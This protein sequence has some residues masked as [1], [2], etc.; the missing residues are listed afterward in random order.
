MSSGWESHSPLG[1]TDPFAGSVETHISGVLFAGDLAYKQLKPIATPFLDF[2]TVEARR[3]ALER[4]LELNSRI[5]P[6][7]YLGVEEVHVDG[8]AAEYLLVM[9][10]MPAHRRL[11][12]LLH[13]DEAAD[14]LRAVARKV[15][16]FHS[17]LVPDD[18]AAETAG[19]DAERQR[20]IDNLDEMRD[21]GTFEPE[22][23]DHIRGHVDRYLDGRDR[24]FAE[25]AQRGMARDGHGDLLADDI[26]VVDDSVQILDCLAFDD[27]LRVGDI[28]SDV[29]FL[30]MDI[31]RLAGERAAAALMRWYQEF[32]NEHHPASLAHFYVAYRALVRAKVNAI[33]YLQTDDPDDLTMA[34]QHLGQA[35]AHVERSRLRLILVGGGPGT[36][37]STLAEGVGSAMRS[38]VLSSD[39]IRKELA[40][41]THET[42]AVA[43]P[44]SGIYTA[45]MTERTYAELL[46]EAASLLAHGETVVCDASWSSGEHRAAAREVGARLGADVVEIEC[47]LDPAVAK[48]RIVRRS[49]SPWTV[50][51]ATP[52]IVDHMASI[53]DPWPEAKMIDTSVPAQTC[54]AQALRHVLGFD[55]ESDSHT[56][57]L[58]VW[59]G[60]R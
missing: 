14:A 17:G 47:G 20:W 50:S 30:I 31:E 1:R 29:A 39:E 36:G 22:F 35:L 55:D 21:L 51:D 7:V 48:E 43:E 5:A 32:S 11:S 6:D 28:L 53:H 13:G 58:R 57:T 34:S 33:R 60:H 10:R 27:E 8:E 2:S 37:K 45:D 41:I 25:R 59:I 24:L 38:P 44:D 3:V 12:A 42:R 52:E 54:R 56:T 18:R 46:D 9:R 4:E 16:A 49:A 19:I 40:G 26:F 15:A 23:L